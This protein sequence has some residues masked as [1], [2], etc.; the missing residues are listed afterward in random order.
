MFLDEPSGRAERAL[1]APK[2]RI[3]YENKDSK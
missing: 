3:V 2:I 1:A